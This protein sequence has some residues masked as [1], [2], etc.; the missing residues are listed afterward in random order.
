MRVFIYPLSLALLPITA[1]Q[2]ADRQADSAKHYQSGAKTGV[3][4]I[5]ERSERADTA[6]VIVA[7]NANIS[8]A[9]Q[10][11]R[12]LKFLIGNQMQTAADARA[13]ATTE[14]FRADGTW[15]ALVRTTVPSVYRGSWALRHSSPNNYE[16]CV[17]MDLAYVRKSMPKSEIC[18]R[19]IPLYK[20]RQIETLPILG[21]SF[22]IKFNVL[23]IDSH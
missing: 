3:A 20:E 15:E 23:E 12:F 6:P 8:T 19:F 16:V 4:A 22:P 10:E 7:S 17:K 21:P 5:N 2:S 9:D 13:P 11:A 1:C 14:L 18:R